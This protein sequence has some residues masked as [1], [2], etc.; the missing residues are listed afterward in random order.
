M[1]NT[2]AVKRNHKVGYYPFKWTTIGEH[3]YLVALVSHSWEW[4]EY[5]GKKNKF[6]DK[7]FVISEKPSE[8]I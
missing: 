5:T 4:M 1:S 8:H 3:E 7:I 6:G 2:I